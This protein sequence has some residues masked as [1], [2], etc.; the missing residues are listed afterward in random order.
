MLPEQWKPVVGFEGLYEVSD[1]GRVRSLDRIVSR[2]T[3]TYFRA[4]RLM[5]ISRQKTGY[6]GLRLCKNGK[7]VLILVHHLV[8]SAFVGPRP[9]RADGCHNDGCKENNRLSNLRWDTRKGNFAD[10]RKHGTQTRGSSH[11]A[12]RLNET[13][14]ERIF[15]LRA[16]GC[17]QAQIGDWMGIHQVHVGQ[18]LRRKAWAHV[19]I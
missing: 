13:D 10:K 14:V 2:P 11:P 5:R 16:N 17:T 4:G 6:L 18:I 1:H 12:A 19:P 3:G 9:T 15:D 8:L 7:S